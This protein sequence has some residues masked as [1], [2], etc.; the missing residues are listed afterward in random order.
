M[1]NIIPTNKPLIFGGENGGME[2]VK[3][4]LSSFSPNKKIYI[5]FSGRQSLDIVH[6]N[7]YDAYSSLSVATSPLVCTQDSANFYQ[8]TVFENDSLSKYTE[9]K[10]VM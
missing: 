4:L 2:K 10:W 1:I 9:K 6:E 5:A 3:S 8:K 7:F